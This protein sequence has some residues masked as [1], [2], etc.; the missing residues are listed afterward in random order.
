MLNVE[1]H[2]K[3]LVSVMGLLMLNMLDF[4]GIASVKSIAKI[5]IWR[6]WDA[7]MTLQMIAD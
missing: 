4:I 3:R 2:R 1:I 5:G 6:L 7:F